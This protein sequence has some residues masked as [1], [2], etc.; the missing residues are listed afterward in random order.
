MLENES[1]KIIRFIRDYDRANVFY[2]DNDKDGFYDSAFVMRALSHYRNVENECIR[3]VREMHISQKINNT[4]SFDREDIQPHYILAS[5][6]SLYDTIDIHRLANQ[7]IY[8]DHAR[9][10]ISGIAIVSSI[11]RV[12]NLIKKITKKCKQ[13][14]LRYSHQKI[15]YY[16]PTAKRDEYK[17]WHNIVRFLKRD[18]FQTEQEYRFL[19]DTINLQPALIDTIIFYVQSLEYIDEIINFGGVNPVLTTYCNE[20]NIVYTDYKN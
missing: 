10:T 3:D 16:A 6:W 20:R 14:D 2:Y 8:N 11:G 12:A 15:T 18:I 1:T 19:F 9:D 7:F 4:E 17:N 5:C 13:P